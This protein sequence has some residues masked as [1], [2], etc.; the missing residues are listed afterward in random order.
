MK[1][2]YR[3]LLRNPCLACATEGCVLQLK[4]GE[5]A[6][7]YAKQSTTYGV[8]NGVWPTR[9]GPPRSVAEATEYRRRSKRLTCHWNM[10]EA[11]VSG[12]Q[13]NL[14]K[15]QI[16]KNFLNIRATVKFLKKGYVQYIWLAEGTCSL[17]VSKLQDYSLLGYD[18]MQIYMQVPTLWRNFLSPS[19][20]QSIC[21][22]IVLLFPLVQNF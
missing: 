7:R 8:H 15:S 22:Y 9:K 18:V 10:Q 19:S 20:G 3:A 11:S 13:L 16:A 17:K 21:I 5:T 1:I 14:R 4:M 6:S 2:G 12:R